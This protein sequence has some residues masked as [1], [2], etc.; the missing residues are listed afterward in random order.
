MHVQYPFNHTESAMP[1]E[2]RQHYRPRAQ[3]IPAW[4]WRLWTWL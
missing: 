1:A 3:R 2:L 4:M